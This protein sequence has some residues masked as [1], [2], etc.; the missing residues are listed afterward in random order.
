MGYAGGRRSP[1]EYGGRL[2]GGIG[3]VG[4]DTEAARLIPRAHEWQT[5]G[6]PRPGRRAGPHDMGAAL[7]L[8]RA[9]D[10]RLPVASSATGVLL[11]SRRTPSLEASGGS[12]ASDSLNGRPLG[13]SSATLAAVGFLRKTA[14]GWP[15]RPRNGGGWRADGRAYAQRRVSTVCGLGLRTRGHEGG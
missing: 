9:R 3:A 2:A 11:D 15:Q 12:S 8:P 10:G 14:C 7:M 13:D 6:W 1:T 5:K 4:V